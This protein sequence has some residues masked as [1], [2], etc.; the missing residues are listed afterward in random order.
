MKIE[1]GALSPKLSE[2]LKETKL[3]K[4]DLSAFDAD[5]GAINRL[6][7]GYMLTG[8]ETNKARQRLLKRIQETLHYR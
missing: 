3:T 5:S 4:D 6:Y 7:V 8:D 2:Q 1:F